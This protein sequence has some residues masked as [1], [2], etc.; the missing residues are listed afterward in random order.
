MFH[1]K[2]FYFCETF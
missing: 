2:R 1:K